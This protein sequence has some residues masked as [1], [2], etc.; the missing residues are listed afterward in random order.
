MRALPAR[1]IASSALCAAL[2]VGIA[3]PAAM[4]ADSTREHSHATSHDARLRGA[5]ALLVQVRTYSG[6]ELTPVADLLTAVI[7]AD[8]GQLP[9][10]KAEKLGAAAK[11]AVSKA[12]AKAS[13]TSATPTASAPATGVLLP[14][15]AQRPADLTDD[16]L[17]AVAEAVDSLVESITADEVDA[18]LPSVDDLLDLVKDLID[19]LIGVDLLEQNLLTETTSSTTAPASV[20]PVPAVTLPVITPLLSVLLPAS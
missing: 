18:V 13:A 14:A 8:N 6:G 20:P 5:E 15:P 16:G 12:V 2:L 11:I 7:E 1:R 19:A 9:E 10:A 17:D 3:G 4:A